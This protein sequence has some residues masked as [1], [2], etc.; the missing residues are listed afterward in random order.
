MGLFSALGRLK[1]KIR[2]L[3]VIGPVLG[4]TWVVVKLPL[5]AFLKRKADEAVKAKGTLE[6]VSDAA[7]DAGVD[8]VIDELEKPRSDE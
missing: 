6:S 2:S 3:P 5:A 4:V 7:I 8:A 1:R